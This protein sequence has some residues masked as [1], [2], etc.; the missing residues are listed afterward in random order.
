M[1]LTQTMTML[2][3]GLGIPTTPDSRTIDLYLPF[4]P[5]YAFHCQ[6]DCGSKH[7]NLRCGIKSPISKW[8]SLRRPLCSMASTTIWMN[9]QYKLFLCFLIQNKDHSKSSVAL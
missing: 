5:F 9:R 2:T 1:T 4:E 6:I 7:M 8:L 3:N